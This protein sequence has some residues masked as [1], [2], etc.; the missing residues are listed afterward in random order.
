LPNF[1]SSSRIAFGYDVG[2]RKA[3][4]KLRVGNLSGMFHHVRLSGMIAQWLIDPEQRQNFR[5]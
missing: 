5:N 4:S 3:L 1:R 2:R